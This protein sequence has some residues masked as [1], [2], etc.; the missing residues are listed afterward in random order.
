MTRDE[1]KK[2]KELKKQLES[3]SKLEFKKHHLKK[4]DYIFYTSDGKMFY[5]MMFFMLNDI[6]K[7]NFY[8]KPLWLDDI[9]WEV[10]DMDENKDEPIS[11][12]GVGAFTINPI[13]QTMKNKV[14][15]LEGIDDFVTNTF[16]DFIE[17]SHAYKEET[18]LNDYTNISYQK[19]VINIIVLI[20]HNQ[21]EPALE[22]LASKRISDFISNGKCFSDLAIDFIKSK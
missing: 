21:F 15:S 2:N 19:E 7:A 14:T 17:F 11:L 13:A 1:Q 20:H 4:R 16:R 22:I 5:A 8:A 12:R 3:K 6:V 18:F 10:L 9:L